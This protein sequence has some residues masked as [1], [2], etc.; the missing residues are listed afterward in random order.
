MSDAAE[1]DKG[2]EE[3]VDPKELRRGM[4]MVEVGDLDRDR[5]VCQCNDC[6]EYDVE[7]DEVGRMALVFD[8]GIC[9]FARAESVS[10]ARIARW[11]SGREGLRKSSSD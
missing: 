3:D 11:F 7:F 1:H 10:I 8:P 9:G 4:A 5:E 6:I 2:E